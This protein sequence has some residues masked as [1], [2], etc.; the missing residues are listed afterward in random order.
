MDRKFRGDTMSTSSNPQSD[1]QQPG[2]SS[3]RRRKLA[4][5]VVGIMM[6]AVAIEAPGR[7]DSSGT[8]SE[9]SQPVQS[10][11]QDD[12]DRIEAM[13]A[14]SI[15]EKASEIRPSVQVPDALIEEEQRPEFDFSAF[16][17]LS[18]SVDESVTNRPA[19]L[20]SAT[21]K[22]SPPQRDTFSSFGSREELLIPPEL[23][24]GN[25]N[26]VAADHS[27]SA[28]SSENQQHSLAAQQTT[29]AGAPV[30]VEAVVALKKKTPTPA[31]R[32]LTNDVTTSPVTRMPST[33]TADGIQSQT[34]P[35]QTEDGQQDSVTGRIRFTG[36][37]FPISRYD[38]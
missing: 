37:I 36:S 7:M 17:S 14:Q 38:R 19:E 9:D 18:G 27:P 24:L 8:T 1:D 29:V 33:A 16:D 26:Q 6:I 21:E 30:E 10:S 15:P 32:I 2:W 11:M 35:N 31:L 13:L 28:T 25:G 4:A 22:T 5:G 34:K 23:A 3:R 20:D 12:F